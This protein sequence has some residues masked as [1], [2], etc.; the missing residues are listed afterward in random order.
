[1]RMTRFTILALLTLLMLAFAIPAAAECSMCVLTVTISDDGTT[2]RTDARCQPSLG[3]D[4]E[5]CRSF[6]TRGN[7][8]CDSIS[9]VATCGSSDPRGTNNCPPWGC[10]QYV[11]DRKMNPM[12]RPIVSTM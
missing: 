5:N 6:N 9:L 10:I 2:Q 7:A 11:K 4:I 3:G 8:F 1:M 12:I